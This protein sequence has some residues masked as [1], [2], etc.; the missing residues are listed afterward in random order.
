MMF[1]EKASTFTYL[2]FYNKFRKFQTLQNT[3][4]WNRQMLTQSRIVNFARGSNLWDVF[5]ISWL[6][7]TIWLLKTGSIQINSQTLN[8]LTPCIH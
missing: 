3:V 7:P 4:E 5:R 2:S 1:A 6:F 8:P